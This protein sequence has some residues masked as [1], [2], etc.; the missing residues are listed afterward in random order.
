MGKNQQKNKTGIATYLLAFALFVITAMLFYAGITMPYS[1]FFVNIF[2]ISGAVFILILFADI[3]DKINKFGGYGN[4]KDQCPK[5]HSEPTGSFG[6]GDGSSD[7]PTLNNRPNEDYGEQP[8]SPTGIGNE[9]ETTTK[10]AEQ[11]KP[12]DKDYSQLED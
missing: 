11:Q 5:D 6:Y 1:T 8:Y 7:Y 2:L 12:D 3:V 4:K 10:P 9:A